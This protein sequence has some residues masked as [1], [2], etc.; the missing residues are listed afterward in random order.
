MFSAKNNQSN[1]NML[2]EKKVKKEIIFFIILAVSIPMSAVAFE[3]KS[4]YDLQIEKYKTTPALESSK[5]QTP[6]SPLNKL[7][8]GLI[9]VPLFFMEVP[10]SFLR[11]SKDKDIAAGAT[12]G[13]GQG[14]V[15]SLFRLATGLYDMVTFP[16]PPYDK[17]LMSPEYVLQS[18][19]AEVSDVMGVP[20][21]AGSLKSK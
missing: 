7:G 15:V 4:D 21:A 16:F 11:V 14:V 13:M 10:A 20:E 9:N 2:E 17:P 5:I 8:R 12:V 3:L 1:A 6:K 19:D 18:P